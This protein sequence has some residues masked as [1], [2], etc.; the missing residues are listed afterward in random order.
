MNP[1]IRK[2]VE[3]EFL[4]RQAKPKYTIP[5][6]IH[7]YDVDEIMDVL[8][9]LVTTNVTMGKKTIEFEKLF[10]QYIGAKHGIMV[11]SGS[12]ADLIA[13]SAL[14]NPTLKNRIKPGDEI[15]TPATTWSTTVFSI[16]NIN[17]VPVI[18]DVGEDYLIDIEEIKK[19]ITP[20]T[21]AIMPVHLLGNPCDMK[22]IMDLAEDHNL[23][24]VE[25]TCEAHG[26][27]FHGKK[28]GSFGDFSAFS[29]FFS[30][31]ISTIEGGMVLTNNEIYSELSRSLRAHGWVRELDKKQDFLNKY[32]DIDPRFLF[33]NTGYNLRPTELQSSIG[34]RQIKKL[35]NFIKIRRENAAYWIKNLKKF[36]DTF[37]LPEEKPN[38][39]HVWFG[40]PL[41]IKEGAGFT[42]KEL[43]DFLEKKKIETRPVMV[44]NICEQP[45]MEFLPH[46]KGK[47]DHATNVMR[48]AFF[49]G[50]HQNVLENEMKYVVS[51]FE[52]FMEGR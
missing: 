38:T 31:H 30:H 10:A 45:A 28:A 35:E 49:F 18:V 7:S 20:K 1:E 25:D 2:L 43:T 39:R 42:R 37:V 29:F 4:E 23:F 22:A 36:S 9:C 3:K 11:N 8:D 21:K 34:I 33:V 41:A 47:L 24:V 51:C 17:A 15:I 16:L 32:P 50:N 52:E 12:S 5:L 26:A 44:G 19:H 48:N 6:N 13:L 40:F 46:K 27:E 14:S